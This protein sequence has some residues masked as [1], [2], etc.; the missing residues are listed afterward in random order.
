[1]SKSG[2]QGVAAKTAP[3]HHHQLSCGQL[4]RRQCR[5]VF[6]AK[7]AENLHPSIDR[8]PKP[9]LIDENKY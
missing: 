1:M 2:R 9:P 5:V 7:S 6:S 4:P 8:A 3:Q